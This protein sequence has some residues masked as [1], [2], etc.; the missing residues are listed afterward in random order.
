MISRMK[1]HFRG[2]LFFVRYITASMAT[3]AALLLTAY[4]IS[5]SSKYT[6]SEIIN[7]IATTWSYKVIISVFLLPVAIYLSERVKKL[8]GQIIMTGG[9]HTIHSR[10]FPTKNQGGKRNESITN[11]RYSL[12]AR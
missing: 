5:L 6:S 4:P 10:Y 8:R 1:T 3:Q 12:I 2:K 9:C 7:I 11:F